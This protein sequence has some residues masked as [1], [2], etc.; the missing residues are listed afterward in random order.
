V[1]TGH[2]REYWDERAKENAYFFVDSRLDYADPDIP[3]FWEQ[4]EK[5]IDVFLDALEASIEPGDTIVEIGCGVGRLTRPLSD[6]ATQV[7]A[8]DISSEMLALAGKNLADRDNVR[9]VHGDGASL[10]G[11]DDACADACVSHVVFQHIPDPEVVL[12]YVRD[13]GRVLKPGGWAGFQ[14]STDPTVHRP[15]GRMRNLVNS[16]R[17]R[18]PRG[19][20][21][22][23]WLGALT[24]LDELERVANDAGMDVEHVWGRGTQY[25]LVRLRR[26]S[27]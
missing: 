3:G 16:V 2:Q 27:A 5:D 8:F 9:L 24:D 6:R 18:G 15:Q 26:T 14:V 4:G 25:C 11:V 13:I 22:P 1:D 17:G 10:A 12:A 20:S 21:D 23:A 19:Q 7:V